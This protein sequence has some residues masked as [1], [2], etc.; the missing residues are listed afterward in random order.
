MDASSE[1]TGVLSL[2]VML[3]A[4]D[5]W[6]ASVPDGLDVLNVLITHGP[7]LAHLDLLKLGYPQLLQTL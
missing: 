4:L 5:V 1:S 7:P 6:A 3:T 2:P